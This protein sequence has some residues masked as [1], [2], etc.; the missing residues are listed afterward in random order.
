MT[1]CTRAFYDLIQQ[2]REFTPLS[3]TNA[4]STSVEQIYITALPILTMGPAMEYRICLKL[5][6][7]MNYRLNFKDAS[8]KTAASC[9]G[10]ARCTRAATTS[11]TC[12]PS[13]RSSDARSAQ[14]KLV[15]EHNKRND[16][17]NQFEINWL[18]LQE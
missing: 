12:Q 5:L 2:Q 3:L 6:M 8:L 10:L 18:K 1:P 16:E 7:H 14:A 4:P 13:H 11:S 17:K 9:M 15:P